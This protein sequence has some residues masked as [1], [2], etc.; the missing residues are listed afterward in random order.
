MDAEEYSLVVSS[1]LQKEVLV[2]SVLLIAVMTSVLIIT[3]VRVPINLLSRPPLVVI[4][5][6]ILPRTT[7]ILYTL[8]LTARCKVD[9][10]QCRR[11]DTHW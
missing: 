2:M 5:T 3:I 6:T 10:H 9:C 4:T 11:H 8:K 1:G 7:I